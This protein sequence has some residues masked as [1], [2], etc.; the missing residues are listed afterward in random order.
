MRL[1]TRSSPFNSAGRP[2]WPK[3]VRALTFQL[4]TTQWGWSVIGVP[5]ETWGEAILA[6]IVALPRSDLVSGNGEDALIA[7]CRRFIGGHKVPRRVRFVDAL[8]KSAIGKDA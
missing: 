1:R 6:V 5:D 8:P 4:W 2:A 3:N 7:H